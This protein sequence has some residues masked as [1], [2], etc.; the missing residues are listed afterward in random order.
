MTN[1]QSRKRW[2]IALLISTILLAWV[3]Y[4][5][6]YTQQ[7]AKDHLPNIIEHRRLISSQGSSSDSGISFYDLSV[8]E[9]V[10][11]YDHL[12][13]YREVDLPIDLVENTKVVLCNESMMDVYEFDMITGS[14]FTKDMVVQNLP[15]VIISDELALERFLTYS[16]VGQKLIID[17]C[18]YI[19]IGVYDSHKGFWNDIATDGFKRVYIPYTSYADEDME[20]LDG[21]A[22][23]ANEETSTLYYKL[24]SI[25]GDKYASYREY[26]FTELGPVSTQYF[27]LFLLLVLLVPC[28]IL[29]IL[30]Y[31]SVKKDIRFFISQKDEGYFLDMLKQDTKRIILAIGKPIACI[32]GIVLLLLCNP[33][34]I[35]IPVDFIPP[36]K[37]FDLSFYQDAF[38]ARSIVDNTQYTMGNNYWYR[39]FQNTSCIGVFFLIVSI[40][41][42]TIFLFI[43]YQYWKQWRQCWKARN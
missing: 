21:I 32:A 22:Y 11:E 8:Y 15:Y 33:Y 24:E 16:A 6:F 36:E 14:T 39:L 2:G 42:F 25:A 17:G 26:D 28:V 31:Q 30:A 37:I 13:G 41:L 19:V 34:R 1:L 27:S 40:L 10:F 7:F 20:P 43:L 38:L 9:N 5:F 12:A 29:A 4:G 18:E 35:Q 3:L 23:Q